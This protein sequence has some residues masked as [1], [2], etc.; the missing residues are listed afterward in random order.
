MERITNHVREAVY[1][2]KL[3]GHGG[4]FQPPPLA[5]TPL[6]HA[7]QLSRQRLRPLRCTP[8]LRP[9]HSL[10]P[11]ER[12][13]GVSQSEREAV[14]P[15][16]LR[17]PRLAPFGKSSAVAIGFARGAVARA[18]AWRGGFKRSRGC[19]PCNQGTG[20]LHRRRAALPAVSSPL[21]AS[22]RVPAS[23]F[24]EEGEMAGFSCPMVRARL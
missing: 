10:D 18:A 11:R 22:P 7:F 1:S 17:L 20:R 8:R 23:T 6:Q 4:C 13:A 9:A 14:F 5:H 3:G 2:L 16:W 24:T 15:A 12:T 19:A 21:R